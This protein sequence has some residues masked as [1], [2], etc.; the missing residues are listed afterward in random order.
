MKKPAPSRREVLRSAAILAAAGPALAGRAVHAEV[1]RPAGAPRIDAVLRTAIGS[2]E[3]PGVVAMAANE[4]GVI[5]EGVFGTRRVGSGQAMTRDTVFRVASMIKTITSVAAMQLVEQGKLGLEGPLP[6]IDPIL[7][8]P[9]V[10]DGFDETGKPLLR[11]AKRPITLRHLLTHTSGFCYRL[12]DAELGRY[13]TAFNA[14][15]RARRA[16]LPRVPLMFDPGERWEYGTSI[17][18]VGRIVETVSEQRLDNYFREHIFEPLGMSDTGFVIS[19]EQHAREA[20]VHKRKPDGTLEAEPLEKPSTPTKFSGGGGIYS[21]APDYLTLARMLLNSGSLKGARI[22]RPETVALMNRNQT[23]EIE[24]GR[25]KTVAP[26]LSNDVDFFPGMH[27]RWGL[28]YMITM[29][30]VPGGRSAGSLTWAGLLNTYY[31]IDP[32]KRVAAV[33]MTQVLP[34]ADHHALRVYRDFERGVYR[35][36]SAA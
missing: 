29:G 31:W 11:P 17:D 1:S 25:L 33:F 23:G 24:T 8:A 22:L 35:A 28:G 16:E 7:N 4:D 12:W 36:V 32:S 18:W 3:V 26:S 2:H 13:A 6:E 5:Y 15:P 27:L 9:Q 30:A 34:F 19:A 21:T 14:M 10:L 20:S